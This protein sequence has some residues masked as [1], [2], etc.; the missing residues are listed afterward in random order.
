ML[1]G[2]ACIVAGGLVAAITGPTGFA[3]G[4]WMAAYL[5]LVAGVSQVGLGAGQALLPRRPPTRARTTWQLLTWNTGNLA[6][7]TGTLT[8]FP[9]LVTVGGLGL[10]LALVM[11]LHAV[12][13]AG[14]ARVRSL[15]AYRLL[16]ALL[17]ISIPV[18]LFLS[19]LRH[20]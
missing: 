16:V 4:S 20:G 2:L 14:T 18:G 6:V 8:G 7:I 15:A 10:F 12:R 3:D 11:F 9:V 19:F 5:V 1:I 13:Q 17:A